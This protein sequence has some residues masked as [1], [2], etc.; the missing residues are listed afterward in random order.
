[1][2]E[3][4][5]QPARVRE[6]FMDR[7]LVDCPVCGGLAV[8]RLEEPNPDTES[9]GWAIERLVAPRRMTCTR[10]SAHRRQ[11]RRAWARPRMGLSLR[12]WA[13]TRHG[14]LYAYNEDHL[15]YLEDYV[16]SAIRRE[17][18]TASFLNGSVLSR[19]P[20]WVKA[21]KNRAEVLKAIAEMRCKLL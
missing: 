16:G 4:V 15:A 3:R 6:H 5:G 21:A 18:R 7:I 2:P 1:M 13:E 19:L 20:A 17:V 9:I 12:L 11:G 14:I 10:C 8:V